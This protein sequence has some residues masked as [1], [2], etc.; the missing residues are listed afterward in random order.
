MHFNVGHPLWSFNRGGVPH[1]EMQQRGSVMEVEGVA[2]RA[3][4]LS[5]RDPSDNWQYCQHLAS[6]C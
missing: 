3:L 4:G 6:S 2:H 1:V 5:P